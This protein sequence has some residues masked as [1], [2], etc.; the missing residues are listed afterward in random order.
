MTRKKLIRTLDKA[1]EFF[2]EVCVS[3]VLS[4]ITADEKC[5][6]CHGFNH[7]SQRDIDL[8]KMS[9]QI[10]DKYESGHIICAICYGKRYE[11]FKD[12]PEVKKGNRQIFVM[13]LLTILFLFI[14]L[15]VL[16][17]AF[18]NHETFFM[19]ISTFLVALI[20]ILVYRKITNNIRAKMDVVI[21][22]DIK[23]KYM[24]MDK[25]ANK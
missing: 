11:L 17:L 12:L 20:G 4:G 6:C 23:D 18:L 15:I 21:N 13:S 3:A 16:V 5:P 8:A 9:P 10:L 7:I 19:G 22:K 2:E 25:N 14:T 1:N 24:E